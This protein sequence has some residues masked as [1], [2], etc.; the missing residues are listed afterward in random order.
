MTTYATPLTRR[1]AEAEGNEVP[2]LALDGLDAPATRS[3]SAPSRCSTPAR[4][5]PPDNLVVYVP[6]A[7]VLFGGC[8]VHEASRTTAGN[9]ADADLNAWP[10]SLRRVRARYPEAQVVVP[11][12]G[13]PGD[14]GLLDHS[15]ALVEAARDR[16]VGG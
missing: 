1:L 6:E 3:G 4:A 14:L 9:V 11:G 5:T 7:R 2:H 13:V 16:P 12:H 10:E 15:V 8:A